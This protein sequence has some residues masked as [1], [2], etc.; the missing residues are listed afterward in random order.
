[1]SKVLITRFEKVLTDFWSYYNGFSL[2]EKLSEMKFGIIQIKKDQSNI[3]N[4]PEKNTK[5]HHITKDKIS[6]FKLSFPQADWNI[7]YKSTKSS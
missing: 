3:L 2:E 7:S 6:I 1:M 5:T 4:M